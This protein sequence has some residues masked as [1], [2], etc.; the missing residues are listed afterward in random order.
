MGGVAAPLSL[1]EREQRLALD[2]GHAGQ[3]N[4]VKRLVTTFAALGVSLRCQVP[5]DDS[6][7][8]ASAVANGPG[9]PSSSSLRPPF[10]GSA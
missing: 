9:P 6:I 4:D 10:G 7:G 5:P 3:A 8:A 2:V 1:A